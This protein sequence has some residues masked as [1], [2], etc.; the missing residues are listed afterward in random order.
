MFCASKCN[1]VSEVNSVSK[2][3]KVAVFN[4]SICKQTL[5]KIISRDLLYTGEK[6]TLIKTKTK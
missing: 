2:Q 3:A 4:G 6:T 5:M 1:R